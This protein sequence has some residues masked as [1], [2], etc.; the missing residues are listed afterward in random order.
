MEVGEI[1]QELR[2]EKGVYQKDLAKYLNVSNGTISNYEKGTHSPDLDTLIKL[3]DYFGV[4]TDY[5][6]GR[7]K[8]RYNL[9]TLNRS[10]TVDYTVSDF[11]NTVL[12]LSPKDCEYLSDHLNLLK[13]RQRSRKRSKSSGR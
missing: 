5:L 2:Q 10:L 12:E 1:I 13:L 8:Y 7:T 11:V 4:T 6:L 3:A 9:E